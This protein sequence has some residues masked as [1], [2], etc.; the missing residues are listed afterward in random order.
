MCWWLR[1]RVRWG[2]QRP[3][4]CWLALLRVHG[5]GCLC[6]EETYWKPPHR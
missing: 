6:V 3:R 2:W 4:Q 5:R 1:A